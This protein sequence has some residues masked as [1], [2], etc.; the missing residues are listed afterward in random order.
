MTM[1]V[2]NICQ[3]STDFKTWIV[4]N[5]SNIIVGILLFTVFVL[6]CVKIS[7]A[8]SKNESANQKLLKCKI[9]GDDANHYTMLGDILGGKCDQSNIQKDHDCGKNAACF[10]MNVT[11]SDEKR[12][13]LKWIEQTPEVMI[14]DPNALGT[15][16]HEGTLRGCVQGFT[17]GSN[18]HFFNTSDF[19]WAPGHW[20]ALNTCACTTDNCN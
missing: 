4:R 14:L 8:T 19:Q 10:V 5:G 7:N 20:T 3:K 13:H 9:C 1:I 12:E 17:W 16:K 6:V 15:M 2:N 11:Q 18:C